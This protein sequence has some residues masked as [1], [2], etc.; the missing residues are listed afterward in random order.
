MKAKTNFWIV[1]ICWIIIG[2]INTVF[3]AL[4]GNVVSSWFLAIMWVAV[5][6]ICTQQYIIKLQRN[7]VERIENNWR[8]QNAL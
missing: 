8:K 6:M 2:I 1:V 7:Q 3:Y 5:F 4:L